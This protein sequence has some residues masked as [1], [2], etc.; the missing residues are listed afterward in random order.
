MK[1]VFIEFWV[2][3]ANEQARNDEIRPP[4]QSSSRYSGIVEVDRTIIVKQE[5]FLKFLYRLRGEKEDWMKMIP[6]K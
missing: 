4:L 5:R 2:V 1:N 3:S 6:E